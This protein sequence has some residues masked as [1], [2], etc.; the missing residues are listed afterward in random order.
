MHTGGVEADIMATWTGAVLLVVLGMFLHL[1]ACE[2]TCTLLPWVPGL[3]KDRLLSLF[4]ILPLAGIFV[5]IRHG[6]KW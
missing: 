6:G 3:R 2:P 1:T 4:V 5:E